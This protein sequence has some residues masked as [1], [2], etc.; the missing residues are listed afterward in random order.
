MLARF[1]GETRK[2]AMIKRLTGSYLHLASFS[3]P[4]ERESIRIRIWF[5]IRIV[6]NGVAFDRIVFFLSILKLRGWRRTGIHA[7][8]TRFAKWQLLY[9]IFFI[10][11]IRFYSWVWAYDL[12]LL[13]QHP[14]DII[15]PP[16]PLLSTAVVLMATNLTLKHARYMVVVII[17][18][19]IVITVI[20]VI[21]VI[22]IISPLGCQIKLR[23]HSTH[24]TIEPSKSQV[25]A[26]LRQP[27]TSQ[28]GIHSHSQCPVLFSICM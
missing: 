6:S 7:P 11:L 17:I 21:V 9:R 22:V 20:I 13:L 26:K 4:E 3:G 14:P 27:A 2:K 12:S 28:L 16:P 23:N 18:I 8:K 10:H 1:G 25:K 24:F 15:S 5:W 19:T